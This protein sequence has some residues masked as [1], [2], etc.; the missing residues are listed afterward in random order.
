MAGL[1]ITFIVS[2][3][4]EDSLRGGALLGNYVFFGLIILAVYHLSNRFFKKKKKI[5]NQI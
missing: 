3:M 1:P 2:S 5:N 4:F